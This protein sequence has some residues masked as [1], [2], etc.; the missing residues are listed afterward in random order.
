[1]E[2]TFHPKDETVSQLILQSQ[3]NQQSWHQDLNLAPRKSRVNGSTSRQ[4]LSDL[5]PSWLT[6]NLY[7]TLTIKPQTHRQIPLRTPYL[8][9][10]SADPTTNRE[11]PSPSHPQPNRL[12][13]QGHILT[14]PDPQEK[15]FS[16]ARHPTKDTRGNLSP[17]AEA[18]LP[19]HSTIRET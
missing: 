1:M 8:N 4:A 11:Q 18:V 9:P 10:K 13:A 14:F 15:S 2:D 12:N 16:K 3:R 6:Y 19:L 7:E 17:S 5:I